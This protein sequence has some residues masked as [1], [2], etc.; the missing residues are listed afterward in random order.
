MEDTATKIRMIEEKLAVDAEELTFVR[1]NLSKSCQLS[2]NMVTILTSFEN[3]LKQLEE[4][5]LP[6]HQE[7]VTLQKLQENIENTLSAFDH[8]LSYHDS[9]RE[10]ESAIKEG[11]SGKYETYL[12]QMAQIQEAQE[13]FSKNNPGS[14]EL[15]KATSLFTTGRELLQMEFR[16]LLSR[17]SSPVTPIK[18]LDILGTD[19]ELSPEE[20]ALKQLPDEI[21]EELSEITKW[22]LTQGQSTEFIEIYHTTRSATLRKS[23]EGLKDH[24][25]KKS[26]GTGPGGPYSPMVIGG[27]LHKAKDFPLKRSSHLLRS[28]G[29]GMVSPNFLGHR[30]TGSGVTENAGKEEQLD[31]ETACYLYCVSSLVRL[32]QSE[33]QLMTTIIP[34][35][36]QK[37]TFDK[38]IEKPLDTILHDGEAII[39]A[40][41]RAIAKHDYTAVLSI[42]PV[43]K[44]LLAVKP[45]FDET[46]QGTAPS[47]RSKLPSLVS[48]L[49]N[50]GSRAL[51]E[52]F[53]IIKND[54]DKSNM[55]K[56]GTVHGLTSNAL[57][58]LENLLD[59][60]ETAA[61][62]LAT[63]KDPT[64]QM[65]SADP[66][67]KQR[68]VAT[69]VGKVLGALSLNLDQKAKTYSDQYLGAM[70]LLN[71][72][73]YILKSLQ[74]SG[75][76]KL[77]VLSNPDIES[78]YEEIIKEQKKEYSKSWNKVLAHILE[79]NKPVATQ[80]LAPD[81]AK[82]KDKE[83][84]QIK[85]KFKGFN[86]ELEELHRIQSCYAIP[87]STLREAVRRDNRDFIVPRYIQFRDRY[88][89]TNFTKNPEK[90]MK[91]SPEQV[92][93]LLDKFFDL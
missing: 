32:M 78:H 90:Y 20:A 62:M 11:P 53:D 93:D 49:E 37:K 15:A 6:V 85:E 42:F 52:F 80:R 48:S 50:T 9:V 84:Q 40:A 64:L 21:I 38:I 19:E 56:D 2:E 16:N 60:V 89:N 5:I 74:R 43:L 10:L 63:Q 81:A 31:P 14:P 58:F 34:E 70:F 72:Y 24:L 75:L 73:H 79:V 55:P 4:T 28:G 47:T 45:D 27:K 57:I 88:F 61:A 71:N 82:L 92:K 68:R 76:I 22:L 17:H 33:A 87:D 91:Y 77:V 7:T 83:R 29:K 65:R 23:M 3:R 8:V 86:T 67:A 51:E 1:D 41:K 66:K 46:L 69:Y 30:R 25:N 26:G 54:P 13:F 39:S 12:S 35:E 36:S 44:H 18:I 59:Y